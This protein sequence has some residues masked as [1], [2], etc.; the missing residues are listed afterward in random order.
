MADRRSPEVKRLSSGTR[1]ARGAEAQAAGSAAAGASLAETIA[2]RLIEADLVPADRRAEVVARLI[3]GT[4]DAATWRVL[5]EV[6]L[7][8]D[9]RG[10]D[11]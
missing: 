9:T 4:L 6:T 8:A 10:G 5:A 7:D 11:E 1:R 3:G 2:A